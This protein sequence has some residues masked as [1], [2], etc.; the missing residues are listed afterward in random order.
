MNA[1]ILSA[2]HPYAKASFNVAG[3]R[4]KTFIISMF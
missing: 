1:N 2:V 4:S 3:K